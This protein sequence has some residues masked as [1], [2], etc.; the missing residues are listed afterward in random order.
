MNASA[1]LSGQQLHGGPRGAS[2]YT[3]K[4]HHA[5]DAANSETDL[6][7]RTTAR[8]VVTR[9]G[10]IMGA[11]LD[12]MSSI[13]E[14]DAE[15][16]SQS[17]TPTATPRSAKTSLK[18]G[19]RYKKSSRGGTPVRSAVSGL[20]SSAST[21]NQ[22][23]MSFMEY[24]APSE[25]VELR[26]RG[27]RMDV[28]PAFGGCL[29]SDSESEM[30]SRDQIRRHLKALDSRD[31]HGGVKMDVSTEGHVGSRISGASDILPAYES[32][33]FYEYHDRRGSGSSGWKKVKEDG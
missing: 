27:R 10:V 19:G 15:T 26:G 18:F 17:S 25:M 22:H 9:D 4:Y 29:G 8:K 12:R 14:V 11:N 1:L 7:T 23:V 30:Q 20:V 3:G 28:H 31:C 13:D 21:P 5:P 33:G 16:P 32:G 6:I 2:G 24:D